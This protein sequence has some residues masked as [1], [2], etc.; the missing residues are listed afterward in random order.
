MA[1]NNLLLIVTVFVP[2]IGAVVSLFFWGRDRLQRRIGFAAGVTA[3]LAS[4]GVL[5]A[6][7]QDGPQ[8]Y[9]LGGWD[10]PFGI[11]LVGD[12]LSSIMVLMS[13]TVLMAG[14]LYALGCHDKVV[15]QPACSVRCSP[16]TCSPCSSLWRSWC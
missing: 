2:L 10:A 12:A 13:S 8:V 11:V 9:R 3:W 14:L 15:K 7:M 4:V 5:V 6:A 1:A 16:A